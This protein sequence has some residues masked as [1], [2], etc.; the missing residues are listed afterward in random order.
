MMMGIGRDESEI[1][2]LC[3][4]EDIEKAFQMLHLSLTVPYFDTAKNLDRFK[5]TQLKSLDKDRNDRSI[6]DE[7]DR[8]MRYGR[9]PWRGEITKEHYESLDMDFVKEVFQ[10]SFCDFSRMK[11]MDTMPRPR[12]KHAVPAIPLIA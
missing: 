10:R 7:E 5:S 3:G 1:T 4:K 8:I 11:I 9:H 2:V 6:F 12:I